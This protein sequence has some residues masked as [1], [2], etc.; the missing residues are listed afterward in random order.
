MR[1]EGLQYRSLA[2]RGEI[3]DGN[4]TVTMVLDGDLPMVGHGKVDLVTQ[5]LDLQILVAPTKTTNTVIRK[6]PV[7]GHILGGTL[8]QVPVRVTGTFEDSKV[9]LLE[10]AAV[11]KNLLGIAERTFLLPVELIRP[12]LPG[13]RKVD[14]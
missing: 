12:V 11:A 2:N 8:V 13:E 1:K 10:P 7:L 4:A 5:K 6:I 9:S 14:Q 3:Q